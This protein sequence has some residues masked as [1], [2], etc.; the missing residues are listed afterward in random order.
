D[1]AMSGLLAVIHGLGNKLWSEG[2]DEIAEKAQAQGW[3][4]AVFEHYQDRALRAFIETKRRPGQPLVVIGHS[5]GGDTLDDFAETGV[6]IDLAVFVD[7][8]WPETVPDTVARVLSVRAEHRGRFH[9]KGG[10]VNERIVIPDTTHTTVDN[11]PQLHNAVLAIMRELAS[12]EPK[13]M[14]P[15]ELVKLENELEIVLDP[16][17]ETASRTAFY[18]AFFANAKPVMGQ[19]NQSQI[20]GLKRL[21]FVWYTYFDG[22]PLR[23]FAAILAYIAIETG[24]RMQP[25]RETYAPT[26]E[27][28]VAKLDAW[29]NSGKAQRAG[30]RSRYW[31]FDGTGHP[32]GRGDIQLTHAAGYRKARE[33]LEDVFG[34][35]VPIDKD[36][37]LALHPIVSAMV[38]IAGCLEGSFTG[39]QLADFDGPDGF[40]WFNSRSIV[41]GDKNRVSYDLDRDGKA[42]KIGDE[43]AGMGALFLTALET[44]SAAAKSAGGDLLPPADPVLP[45]P[46][47]PADPSLPGDGQ[48]G[49]LV[50]AGRQVGHAFSITFDAAGNPLTL[51][52]SL[53]ADAFAGG[54]TAS[55]TIEAQPQE[56][57]QM[58]NSLAGAKPALQSSGVLGGLAA[59]V[60]TVGTVIGTFMGTGGVEQAQTD[61]AQIVQEVSV[62]TTAIGSIMAIIGRWK[63]NSQIKGIFKA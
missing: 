46:G 18:K 48:V 36:Y 15:K 12:E 37:T 23:W 19:M 62:I 27:Q 49:V 25:V 33:L 30:V 45:D 61:V 38:A 5:M 51:D 50:S 9:V 31:R 20:D 17:L 42:E 13:P 56:A 21:L 24:K 60:G 34:L 43:I 59:L 53:P 44:G 2:M 63:A 10:R 11:A 22:K 55:R 52:F 7:S 26:D 16:E 47:L 3:V 4:T 40:D 29:W 35:E 57:T 32:Y 58:A 41:N 8:A 1:P 6:P 54:E 28:A 39:K 14:I